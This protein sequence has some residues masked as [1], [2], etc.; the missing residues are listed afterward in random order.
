MELDKLTAPECW[1]LLGQNGVGRVGYSE[2]AL[3]VIIP[4][5]YTIVGQR[6]MLRCRGAGLAGRLDGQVV[7]FEV[8][9]VEPGEQAGWSVLVTGTCKVL[10]AAGEV[11]R[12]RSVP[13]SW[14]GP[15]HQTL[16][17]ITPG[18][19]EG[20]RITPVPRDG[21][22]VLARGGEGPDG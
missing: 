5:G 20:R 9:H 3:P 21:E 6:V 14:A 7:A 19:V 15:D 22:E 1:A 12:A 10:T 18:K 11:V 17:A 4:V 16:V 8:D 2:R 13:P